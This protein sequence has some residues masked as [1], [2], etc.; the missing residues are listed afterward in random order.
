MDLHMLLV[1]IEGRMTRA[2]AVPGTLSGCG[3]QEGP[4]LVGA[5]NLAEAGH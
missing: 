4:R 1:M 5:C 3:F 2:V